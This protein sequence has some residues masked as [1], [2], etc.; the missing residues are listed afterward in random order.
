MGRAS[1]IKCW[2]K[3]E[4]LRGKMEKGRRGREQLV[5]QGHKGQCGYW[6]WSLSFSLFPI[7]SLSRPWKSISMHSRLFLVILRLVKL[8][9]Y[10]EEDIRYILAL[11]SLLFPNPNNHQIALC[12][13]AELIVTSVRWNLT[14]SA[15]LERGHD[16]TRPLQG[17]LNIRIS[18]VLCSPGPTP[19]AYTV[20]R[21]TM[22]LQTHFPVLLLSIIN[23]IGLQ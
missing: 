10:I 13:I 11:V 2:K 16:D 15:S 6:R 20:S 23:L 8:L 5:G 21:G 14:I 12:V 4:L 3:N 9:F 18:E 22:L 19:S 1:L 7:F 17:V